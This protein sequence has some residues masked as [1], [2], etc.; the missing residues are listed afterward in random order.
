MFFS[1]TKINTIKGWMW[2]L[3]HITIHLTSGVQKMSFCGHTAFEVPWRHRWSCSLSPGGWGRLKTWS[4]RTVVWFVQKIK[5]QNQN[6]IKTRT[7]NNKNQVNE[8]HLVHLSS[9]MF[10]DPSDNMSRGPGQFRWAQRWRH[11]DSGCLRLLWGP[12]RSLLAMDTRMDHG[13]VL[14]HKNT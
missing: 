14:P 10:Q 3:G 1:V 13:L 7:K 12:T 8:K 9:K 4:G 11:G 5:H 2:N 6:W